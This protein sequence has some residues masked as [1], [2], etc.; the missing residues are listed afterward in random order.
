MPKTN[1][2]NIVALTD[3]EIIR[4][5]Q[6]SL[7]ASPHNTSKLFALGFIGL[8][9]SGKSTLAS[10]LEERLNLPLSRNDKIR[11]FLN[12][13][14]FEGSSP[15]QDLMKVLA[16]ARTEWY[17]KHHT[18]VIIDADFS[19]QRILSEQLAERNKAN[20]LLVRITC[21]EQTSIDRITQRLKHGD[22]KGHSQ[23]DLASYYKAVEKHR[24]YPTPETFFSINSEQPLDPQI[25]IL[26][27]KLKANQF[28]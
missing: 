21:S 11:R 13:L 17:Y 14:G 16:E 6:D 20:L 28:L 1:Q 2:N 26:F 7:T 5:Y 15:R 24:L 12:E 4:K 3:E 9:G 10:K 25:E 8:P 22:S 19:E 23:G 27:D 18:S